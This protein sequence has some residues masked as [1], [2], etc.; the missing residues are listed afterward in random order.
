MWQGYV[1]GDVTH[2]PTPSPFIALLFSLLLSY[3]VTDVLAVKEAAFP[4][5]LIKHFFLGQPKTLKKG[6]WIARERIGLPARPTAWCPT[7]AGTGCRLEMKAHSQ[8][9]RRLEECPGTGRTLRRQR[10]C[11]RGARPGTTSSSASTFPLPTQREP[12]FAPQFPFLRPPKENEC[13]SQER[14][15]SATHTR[16]LTG[17]SPVS[18]Y[19]RF[20]R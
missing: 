8:G 19:S 5:R 11:R 1:F 13:P 20:L 18:S 2:P 14:P 4:L 10:C 12:G 17:Y 3:T 9:R 7:A 16:F 6:L 15:S